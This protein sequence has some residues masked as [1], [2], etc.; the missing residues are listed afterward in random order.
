VP[1]KSLVSIADARREASSLKQRL[2]SLYV[3]Y[4]VALRDVPIGF[5]GEMHKYMCVRFAGFLEQILFLAVVGH[6]RDTSS[7]RSASFA[8]SF[9]KAAPNLNPEA[10]EKLVGRFAGDWTQGLADFLDEANRRDQLGTLFKVRNDT[11]H[12]LDYRGTT[13]QVHSYYELVTDIYH[14]VHKTLLA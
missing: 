3:N 10:L 11:A 4:Q 5:Q 6:V 1:G 9:F 13:P 7:P 14:W 2:D 12:G 8:L